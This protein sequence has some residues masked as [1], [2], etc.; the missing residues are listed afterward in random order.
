[1]ANN[2]KKNNYKQNKKNINIGNNKNN[3]KLSQFDKD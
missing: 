3:D 2:K 1:M